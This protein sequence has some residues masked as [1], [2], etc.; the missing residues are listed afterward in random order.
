[1][2]PQ[3]PNA[4]ADNYLSTMRGFELKRIAGWYS[5]ESYYNAELKEGSATVRFALAG[6]AYWERIIDRPYRFGDR[7]ANFRGSYGGTWWKAPDVTLAS[8]KRV[9]LVEGIFDAIALL[10]EDVT[11]VSLMTCNNYP[12]TSLKALAEQCGDGDRPELIF[13]LDGDKAGAGWTRKMVQRAREE[14]WTAIAAQLP[15]TDRRKLDWNEARLLGKLDEKLLTKSLY[16]GALLMAETAGEK[17]NLMY[18]ETGR[19]SFYFRFDNRTFWWKLD[20][21]KFNKAMQVL[22]EDEHSKLSDSQKRD[23]ALRGSGSLTQIGNFWAQI[24]YYQAQAITDEAWYYFRIDFPHDGPAMKNTFNASQLSSAAEFKKRVLHMAPGAMFSG[25]SGQ[26]DAIVED[27]AFNIKVVQTIDF[28]GYSKEHG[29]WIFNDLAVRSGKLYQLNDEDFFDLGKLSIKSLSQSVGLKINSNPREFN[30][31]FV[32]LVWLA[33]GAKGI[34]ALA[35]WFGSLFAEQIRAAMDSFPFL[36]VVGEPGAGKTTLIEFMWKLVGRQDYEG[37]DPSKSTLAAR[38]RNFAQVANLPVVLIEGDRDEDAKKGAFDWSELKTA[39]NGRSTRSRGMKNGGNET[40]EPPFRAS[41]VIAQN[42]Q[43]VAEEAVLS[44]IVHLHFTK[45]QHSTEGR[46]A[47]DALARMDMT[48]VSGFLLAATRK[49]AEVLAR[50]QERYP[51]YDKALQDNSAIRIQRVAKNHAQM[52]ALVDALSVVLPITKEQRDET[53]RLLATMAVDRQESLNSDHALVQQF[54]EIYEY[55]EGERGIEDLPI[56]NHAHGTN[57]I[58]IN[59]QHFEAVCG[60]RR[61]K[62]PAI[63]DLKRVLKTSRLHKFRRIGTVRSAIHKGWNANRSGPIPAKPDT[64][65]CWVFDAT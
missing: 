8:A 16:Y 22:E 6:D 51:A 3:N 14:G 29:A 55:I 39:Y 4:A 36:E 53:I 11:A 57:E 43:V 52:M 54:W 38:A 15:Q 21:E 46:S 49:E 17:A 13:A 64:V 62:F 18:S 25:T 1:M 7:K 30:T 33:F 47:A 37:F 61:I 59:L 41:I 32:D 10:H 44:R 56:L 60:D 58:A 50:M 27:Q 24:L 40:Y 26:L 31:G 5:Q 19:S 9:W 63:G 12:V 20:L 65:K 2:T 48:D 45:A 35:F 34:V 42:A 28:V 23:E